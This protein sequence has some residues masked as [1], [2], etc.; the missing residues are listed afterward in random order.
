MQESSAFSAPVMRGMSMSS[1]P[2]LGE[3]TG[4]IARVDGGGVSDHNITIHKYL[5]SSFILL[6]KFM[7]LSW[8]HV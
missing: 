6:L 8:S 5:R 2:A 1:L 7:H 3:V 4:N